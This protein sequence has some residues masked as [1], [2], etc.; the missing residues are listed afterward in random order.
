MKK[1]NRFRHKIGTILG[2][3][4]YFGVTLLIQPIDIV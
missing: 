2:T 4:A 1:G 3:I